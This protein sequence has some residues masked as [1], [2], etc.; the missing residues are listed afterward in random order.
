MGIKHASYTDIP[1]GK[2]R[3]AAAASRQRIQGLLRNP[4]LTAE[5]AEALKG[6]LEDLAKWEAGTLHES[7]K[8]PVED[9][10]KTSPTETPVET[11]PLTTGT[12]HDITVTEDIQIQEG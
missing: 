10:A 5:Q 2:R 4:L 12:H 8:V 6:Q 1:E 7:T 9:S 11:N 3:E